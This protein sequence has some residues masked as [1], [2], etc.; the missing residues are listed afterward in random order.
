MDGKEIAELNQ[1]VRQFV[2][3]LQNHELA[4]ASLELSLPR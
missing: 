1:G 2:R 3:E 4:S